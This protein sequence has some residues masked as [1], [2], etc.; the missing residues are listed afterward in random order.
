MAEF[1]GGNII[2][3]RSTLPDLSWQSFDKTLIGEF[4]LAKVGEQLLQ[5]SIRVARRHSYAA[6]LARSKEARSVDAIRSDMVVIAVAM[7]AISVATSDDVDALMALAFAEIA[8]VCA[9]E[10]SNCLA[11]A[12]VVFIGRFSAKR[13]ILSRKNMDH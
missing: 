7:A 8:S 12:S 6:F 4:L 5:L 9:A 10:A 13:R 11:S 1:I 3:V 2:A